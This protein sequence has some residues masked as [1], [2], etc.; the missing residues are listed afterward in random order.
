MD[1][2][3]VRFLVPDVYDTPSIPAN[4]HVWGKS[5]HHPAP[6]GTLE[7]G[8]FHWYYDQLLK[9]IVENI[10]RARKNTKGSPTK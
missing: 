6:F 2:Y 4:L 5:E 9:A 8:C 7:E 3:C 10:T 1:Y